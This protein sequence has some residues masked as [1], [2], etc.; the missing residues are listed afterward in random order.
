M[1]SWQIILLI[2]GCIAG[3]IIIGWL[4]YFV[5][6]RL[7]IKLFKRTTDRFFDDF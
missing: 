5:I 4:M 7:F 1:E 3:L 2:F 6:I